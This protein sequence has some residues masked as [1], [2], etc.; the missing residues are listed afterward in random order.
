MVIE[1]VPHG[2]TRGT[3]QS[4]I[5]IF[6]ESTTDTI[7]KQCHVIGEILSYKGLFSKLLP[8]FVIPV[9]TRNKK[10]VDKSTRMSVK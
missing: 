9:F 8:L 4:L 3:L 6:T 7:I 2:N 5:L 1:N 10:N